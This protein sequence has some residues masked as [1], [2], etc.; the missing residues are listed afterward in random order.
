M[1]SSNGDGEDLRN[2]CI[3]R[4]IKI[5]EILDNFDSINAT[6]SENFWLVSSFDAANSSCN[7]IQEI[8]AELLSYAFKVQESIEEA[9]RL[10]AE[11]AEVLTPEQ[12]HTLKE[13]RNKLEAN[14]N[15]LLQHTETILL[16]LNELT[17][18]LLEFTNETSLLHSLFNEKT[19]EVGIIRAESGDPRSLQLS[20]QKA[21]LV[22]DELVSA[23]G[24]VKNISVI[25]SR[26]QSEIDNYVVE[27]RLQYPN[28]QLPSID[29]HELTST[30]FSL[31][32]DYDVLL[33][34]CHEL[35]SY[36]N[37]L[38]SVSLSY[39]KLMEGLTESV[40][41][42]EQQITEV[43][44]ISRSMDTMAGSDL[45]SQLLSELEML[46][47][48]SF[49]QTGKIE[50]VMRSASE[51]SSAVVGTDAH[52]RVTHENQR[53]IDELTRR[54]V[55]A[56]K[57]IEENID[58]WRSKLMKTEGIRSGMANIMNWLDEENK[59]QSIPCAL[60]LHVEKLIE[61]KHQ[62]E[63]RQREI[64]SHQKVLNE[65]HVEAQKMVAAN[66][67]SVA[68]RQILNDCKNAEEKFTTLLA[69]TKACGDN[70]IELITAVTDFDTLEKSVNE[71]LS[72]LNE[73]LSSISLSDVDALKDVYNEVTK[74]MKND[75]VK[76]E[77]KCNWILSVPDVVGGDLCK[78][79]VSESQSTLRKLISR[80]EDLI[81]CGQNVEELQSTYNELS[82]KLSTILEEIEADAKIL[83][84]NSLNPVDL[85]NQRVACQRLQVKHQ[86]CRVQLETLNDVVSKLVESET[87]GRAKMT[88]SVQQSEQANE[89]LRGITCVQQKYASLG[90]FLRSKE[91]K[92][93]LDSEKLSEWDLQRDSLARWIKNE[94]KR[95]A[96]D[97]RIALDDKVIEANIT[98]VKDLEKL[99]TQK[100]QVEMEEIRN[101]AHLLM[102][103]PS[104]LGVSEIVSS[105]NMLEMDWE[106]LVQI[107][108]KINEESGCAKQL[109][110]GTTMMDKW[111]MQKERMISAIGTV[112]I[113]PKV[114]NNQIL[115]IELL[116][117]ELDDQS[118]ARNKVNS[119]A[120]DLVAG[121]VSPESNQQIIKEID[122]LNHRWILFHDELD[123]KKV[124]LSKIKDFGSKFS[125]KQRD[126]K[127][128]L[129]SIAEA[130]EQI[131]LSP[132]AS[133]NDVNEHLK[134]LNALSERSCEID[135][136]LEEVKMLTAEI[137]EITQDH[138]LQTNIHEQ[139][140]AILQTAGE[141]HKKIES[142]KGTA[143]SVRDEEGKTVEE[144][145]KAI[146]WM[147][148][149]HEHLSDIGSLSAIS[150]ELDN[151]RR[152]V[153]E[154]YG[155]VLDKE[156]DITLMRAKLMD[157]MKKTPNKKLKALLDDFSAAWNPLLQEIKI[158]HMNAERASDV[159]HQF[160][161]LSKSITIEINENQLELNQILG[162]MKNNDVCAITAIEEKVRRQE[163][164]V[165]TLKVLLHK[166]EVVTAGPSLKKLGREVE[167]VTADV[168]RLL[169]N[170]RNLSQKMQISKD[171]RRQFSRS[172]GEA[173]Q[174]ID[175]TKETAESFKEAIATGIPSIT[176]EVLL[177]T[178]SDL[179]CSWQKI[180]RELHVAFK[181]VEAVVTREE[182]LVLHE[183]VRKIDMEYADV[184]ASIQ[185]LLDDM[186]KKD[187]I[188]DNIIQK[189]GL[190]GT[191]I[192]K[193]DEDLL[194]PIA[195][196]VADLEEQ[197][198]SC[199]ESLKIIAENEKVLD[200][201]T[202]EWMQLSDSHAMQATSENLIMQQISELKELISKQRADVT[203]CKRMISNMLLSVQE[204][205][206]K[207]EA[208]QDELEALTRN[209]NLQEPLPVEIDDLR[210]QLEKLGAFHEKLR[211]ASQNYTMIVESGDKLMKSADE[212][213]STKT[214][215]DEKQKLID[216][217][218]T[219]NKLLADR[220]HQIC[221]SL[222][223]LGSYTDT[224]NALVAWLQDTEESLQNQRP[225]STEYKVVKEQAR[226]NDILIKHIEEKQQ[227]V[228][229]FKLLIDKV[230]ELIADV[231]KRETLLEQT[232]NI[233]QRYGTL[234][235]SARD[236]RNHLHDALVLTQN[237]VQL[238]EPFKMWLE[239]TERA[240]Q[241]LGHIPTD[242]EK[243]Q[244]QVN[245]HQDLQTN[246]ESKRED[247]ERMT[248]L[249]PLLASLTSDD[250][251][252][253][254]NT[255][256][257]NYIVRYEILSSQVAECGILLQQIGEELASFLK[258]ATALN[259]WLDKI[260][261][262][263]GK[264]DI[265]SIYPEE[266][267]EQTALLADLTME[268]TKQERLVSTVVEDGHE[269][270]RQT[271]G[272][273]AIALQSRIENLRTRYLNLTAI[274]D[275]KIA[276]LSEAL[277]L[278]EKFHDSFDIVHQ[279][280][281]AVEQDLQT[282]DQTPIEA[283]VT[284]IAQ[285]EDDLMKWRPDIEKIND[286]SKQ[287]QNLIGVKADELEIQ[288]DDLTRRFN[289]LAEQ[290]TR[291]SDRLT[292]VEKQSRQV[293]DELDYLNEWFTDARDRLMQAAAP[294]VDPDYVKKQL[295]NQKQ[296]NEDVAVMKARLRD[297]AADAQKVAR[298][299]GGDANGQDLLLV[300]KIETG[301]ALSADVS[302]MGEERLAEL[303]Q[304]LA[305]CLE[306]D[307]SF[308][309][310]DFWLESIENEIDNCPPVITGHQRDQLMQQQFHN[311]EL[312]HS[313]ISHKPLMDR[314]HKNVSSLSELCG[315]ED[316]MQL[317]KVAEDLDERF[318][319]ARDAVRQR[320]EALETA[321][322]QSS[323]LTDRLD[324][325]LANLDGTAIQIRNAEAVPADLERIKSQ[326]GE[327][328][329]L[330][331]QL[332]HKE[333]VLKSVKESAKEILARAKQNDSAALEISLKIKELD[334]LWNEIMESVMMR[335]NILKDTLVKA[336]QFWLELQS[337][338]KAIEELHL[339]IDKIQPVLGE[340]KAIE[341][342][343]NNLM[344]LLLIA[345]LFYAIEGE[346]REVKPEMIDKLRRAGHELCNMIAD[347]EKTHVE[348]QITAAEGGWITVTNMC[349][350]KNADLIEAMEKAMDF[351]GLLTELTNWIAETEARVSQFD[352]LSS[353]SSTNIKNEVRIELASLG[354]L[355]SLLDEKALEKEQL[356]QLCASLCVGSTVQQSASIKAPINDLN[357]RWNK[358]YATLNE[359][360]QKMEKI[361][362]EKGQFSQAYDQLMTWMEKTQK[363]LNKINPH[364]T[365]INEVQVE[366]CKHRVIQNDVLAHEASVDT[367]N[368][369]AKRIIAADP[370]TENSARPMIDKLNSN[371]HIL[372]DKLE[373]VWV[374]LNDARKAAESLGSEVDRWAMWLQDK[375]ADLSHAKPTGGLPETA[376]TQLDDFLVLK[377]EIE[378][379]RVALESHLEAATKY[380]AD[381]ISDRNSWITQRAAQ[382]NKKWVQVQNKVSDREQKLRI[383]L[384]EAQQLHSAMASMNEWLN[385]AENYLGC[386]EHVSR[387]PENVEKQ[388]DKHSVFQTEVLHYRELMSE[389]NSKGT[390]LQY[391]CE[392]KDAIP[393]KNLLV[394]AKHRF[395]KVASRCMDRRKQLDLALQEA[396]LYFGSHSELID[397]IDNGNAKWNG[398][399]YK[400]ATSGSQL[401]LDLEQ[402]REYQNELNERQTMYEATFKRGKSIAEHAP[403]DEQKGINLM[404]EI[405][406]EKWTQLVNTTLYRHRSIEDALLAC[407]QFDEAL[408]SLREWL[409][410]SL[411]D[412]QNL[413]STSVFGDLETVNKLYDDHKELKK[414]IDA[415]QETMKSIKERAQQILDKE[416]DGSLDSL[417]K[418][419]EQLNADWLL[420]EKL[421]AE[422]EER[423]KVSFD[424]AKNF[425]DSIHE[426][427]D[428]LPKIEAR[429][430]TKSQTVEGEVEILEQMDEIAQLHKEMDDMRP[431]LESIKKAG[432]EIELKCHPL[433][434][435][436]MKYWLK[437][438]QNRWEEVT[439][440]VDSKRDD[441][442][443]QLNEHRAKEKMI[444]DLL[445]YI[446]EKSTELKDLNKTSLPEDLEILHSLISEHEQF[447]TNL[448]E[449]QRL[450]DE[451]TKSRRKFP[452]EEQM[453]KS[454]GKALLKHEHRI[455]HPKSD[456]LSDKW[457]KLW[458]DSMDYSRR[459]REM[460]DYLEE[461]KRLESFSFEKWRGRYLEWTDSGKS[462]ISDLFRRI[463]KSGTG[464]VPRSLFIDGIITSKFP[465]TR[466]EMEKVAD[467]FDKGDGMID[468]KE[469]M[470]KLRS[471]FSK[472]LPMKQKTDNEKITEEVIRQTER[473]SCTNRYQ[474]QQVGEGHYRFGETQIKRMVRIL[475]STVMV[476][477]GGGWVALEEFLH[478][479][480]PCRAKG[481]TNLDL[482]R[483]FYDDVRPKN[484]YDTMET[485][486]KSS[487]ST[488][489]RDSPL[490]GFQEPLLQSRF[491][492]TPG[493][494]TKIREKTERSMPMHVA[495][496]FTP[497]SR[498]TAL[499]IS[500]PS[501][502]LSDMNGQ[503]SKARR[504]SAS[505]SVS[506]SGSHGDM[507]DLSRPVSRSS[508][509][510]LDDR[511]TRIP[512]LRGRKGSNYRAARSSPQP[513][514]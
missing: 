170:I 121:S 261:N 15:Q 494:I 243:F 154:I 246:I 314:F 188:L 417:R 193:S 286:T 328:R 503:D 505:G 399:E 464:R 32:T 107:C 382:L 267:N 7:R 133:K 456:Q 100:K 416:M 299:L 46:Q 421:A 444:A 438:L 215:E 387:I 156:G 484:A 486:T 277:L 21:K 500:K 217:W 356:N 335:G 497:N 166:L 460:K 194:V 513:R 182:A 75:C 319:A 106:R 405:L 31:Q 145:E 6:I 306:I 210:L 258:S 450:V 476:R 134:A 379:N 345:L 492:A 60:P 265:L 152:M 276:T 426:F 9:D 320:A 466:L 146:K 349:A 339:R 275:S 378:Q 364:S 300:N 298:A 78:E 129:I 187:G 260:E 163:V 342:Q 159:V 432:Q 112:N 113:D 161:A 190:L 155:K 19:R 511:P 37:Q 47:Q 270:C 488:P 446:A 385:S 76:L 490:R 307:Q 323:Q 481:R 336:E 324:V 40:T 179:E 231:V 257:K 28:A 316:E 221:T 56:Q 395:D 89:V 199:D 305:L 119:L 325:I 104:I 396:Q 447:E 5:S 370:S 26:I 440:A 239:T 420:L 172:K 480:D 330:M 413:E 72:S 50:T 228:D 264:L 376:Q 33:R 255:T 334:A 30:T 151:Q 327:N 180:E 207:A 344:F 468:S 197:N 467:E 90:S 18:L 132:L 196:N 363:I 333:S 372:V 11:G 373:D 186:A 1:K 254:L 208:L 80:V 322:G 115:Q 111:L 377:A 42:L 88:G 240:L 108:S 502:R 459:L 284:V 136:Q 127:M 404:N 509:V 361:L 312:Q 105:Q 14:Y 347:E 189:I 93:N 393:I 273:E 54:Q 205:I 250:E 283:Q 390:K 465:T 262:D 53:Q 303:E 224:H 293:L 110:E 198:K 311:T 412:L 63:L 241:E 295:R 244:Q 81:S 49:E 61:M 57:R 178:V 491:Q 337:C 150:S 68:G 469:F 184:I 181:D 164:E 99:L 506:R 82:S 439:N 226:A 12:F 504:P 222:Q 130:M 148:E 473:C 272:E 4:Q 501:R 308:G 499:E 103:E 411:P 220:E 474:I 95:L 52:Q 398:S 25:T 510:S 331:E 400:Q 453:K 297:A 287:L 201:L 147:K 109:L 123:K 340:P 318:A 195:R 45:M 39:I 448:R 8:R 389:L 282:I 36:L 452:L 442:E 326:I 238:S 425:D 67:D 353:A 384:S 449:K 135:V 158:R 498:S 301:R 102:A 415:H 232:K 332:K 419:V 169:K 131:G 176:K 206:C 374:Q 13:H 266:I 29:A 71:K 213:V 358:L 137:C 247:V 441:F 35:S 229:G 348:Q 34:N 200:E 496:R 388:I 160:E 173:R 367:L 355:R 418:K 351:H 101:K 27:M 69:V 168:K 341:E 185:N 274:A 383:A 234:L 177:K 20:R 352:P 354:D 171:A 477:V 410:K 10:C 470:A 58:S 512:S 461:V 402:H 245:L 350:R 59:R 174:L 397:W 242:E 126:I 143:A 401:R 462:R 288:T 77:C 371:W 357:V 423:L 96:T 64:L 427:L 94:T 408:L 485:F 91:E 125:N 436:P 16:R 165:A 219:L 381:N 218:N 41:S 253:E 304:A 48:L 296:M 44:G 443:K 223:K 51:F 495:G 70:I 409:E 365:T 191:N 285:M 141:V 375:D 235:E 302:L 315:R 24:R 482:Q 66:P 434:E 424:I 237:W 84:K 38:K 233:T 117:S 209:N 211:I 281:D 256:F 422:R 74:L 230:V 204:F 279:W 362:L 269:L 225:P 479:H 508:D 289:H 212:R 360:Q 455:R 478:K 310:L 359:R 120:H 407:G 252:V 451:A 445:S 430:R 97:R 391:Y 86:D 92:I 203:R 124:L 489:S 458:I 406:K 321:I 291:K 493:P 22:F 309:E 248:Q 471:E 43:E 394:S 463:D 368:S 251:A 202:A 2:D 392:K 3:E 227:N 122:A 87:L 338:Q 98:K 157:Q 433:A 114:I 487:R 437:V 73:K 138:S 153:E 507:L 259:D 79:S 167:N 263:M 144:A 403:R 23:K 139:L 435:Q 271:T 249:C 369:A 366:V 83:E 514:T 386:L 428:W 483:N 317:Q 192:R 429:L 142:M 236:R 380:L 183:D 313:I 149:M 17:R 214:L 268:I 294:E 280:M 116:Q 472:K 475:R 140:D 454:S 290:I 329:L 128:Q 162:N 85:S 431:T 292:S 55:R 346:V 216:T 457:K 175:A 343:R 65:L 414:Q 62:S 278:S 118:E